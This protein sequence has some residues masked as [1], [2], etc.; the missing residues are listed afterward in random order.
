MNQD[1]ATWKKVG[2]SIGLILSSLLIGVIAWSSAAR[3]VR[4]VNDGLVLLG[5]LLFA[6]AV[7]LPFVATGILTWLWWTAVLDV[8]GI[9]ESAART[10]PE[11]TSVFDKEKK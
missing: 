11:P 2:I 6:V 1:I 5:F 9:S 8:F 10:A 4:G 7:A 3:C